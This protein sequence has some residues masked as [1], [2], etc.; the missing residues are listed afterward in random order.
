MDI[1]LVTTLVFIAIGV[2]VGIGSGIV[3]KAHATTGGSDI[4]AASVNKY[5]NMSLGMVLV[6]VDFVVIDYFI[7]IITVFICRQLIWLFFLQRQ[8]MKK[9]ALL[10]RKESYLINQ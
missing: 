6:F 7:V 9:N 8:Y 10:I 5:Y 4:I 2:L 1:I 3:F